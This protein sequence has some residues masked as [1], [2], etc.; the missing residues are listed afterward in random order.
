MRVNIEMVQS[1][2]LSVFMSPPAFSW[3]QLLDSPLVL[4]TGMLRLA[5]AD[6]CTEVRSS[7]ESLLLELSP[8]LDEE[9]LES[10]ELSPLLSWSMTRASAINSAHASTRKLK[11]AA[12]KPHTEVEMC[13]ES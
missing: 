11:N 10:E 7:S 3:W 13:Y 4:R 8:L 6:V 12:L 9:L 2:S 5:G 1:N